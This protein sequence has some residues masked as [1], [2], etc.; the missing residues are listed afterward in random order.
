M[1]R[2]LMQILIGE[3]RKRPVSKTDARKHIGINDKK[4]VRKY[5]QRAVQLGFIQTSKDPNDRKTHQLLP[6]QK[7]VDAAR[8]EF[9]AMARLVHPPAPHKRPE[10]YIHYKPIDQDDA[11]RYDRQRWQLVMQPSPDE[12]NKEPPKRSAALRVPA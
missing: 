1:C 10:P 4:I 11:D 2:L 6:T 5:V 12:K 7:L 3:L 8:M 9:F